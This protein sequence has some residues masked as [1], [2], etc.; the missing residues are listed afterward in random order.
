[1]RAP[2]QHRET[3]EIKLFIVFMS[4]HALYKVTAHDALVV[5]YRAHCVSV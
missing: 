2:K 4:F 5:I 1:V 3:I